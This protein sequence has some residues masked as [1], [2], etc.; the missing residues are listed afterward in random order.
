MA[1]EIPQ[2]GV[3]REDLLARVSQWAVTYPVIP[4]LTGLSF[5]AS[6]AFLC[7]VM[8][9]GFFSFLLSW[10]WFMIPDVCLILGIGLGFPLRQVLMRIGDKER[11]KTDKWI[12]VG[13]GLAWILACLAQIYLYD[14]WTV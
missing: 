6:S 14:S 9:P 12:L 11:P 3:D 7:L 13:V 1:E 2:A 8:P 4:L 10:P 5:A